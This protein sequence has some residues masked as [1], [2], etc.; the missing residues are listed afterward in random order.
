MCPQS[1][2]KSQNDKMSEFPWELGIPEFPG[3]PELQTPVERLTPAAAADCGA[4]LNQ[5]A[6]CIPAHH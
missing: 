6:C 4:R 5:R 1:T 3:F 2:K